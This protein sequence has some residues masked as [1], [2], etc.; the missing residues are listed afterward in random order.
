MSKGRIGFVGIGMMGLPMTGR[1]LEA[2]YEVVAYDNRKDAVDRIVAK[3]AEAASSPADV[4]SRTET[5][6][7]SLPVPDIVREVAFGKNGVASGNRRRVFVDLSTTG[8]RVAEGVASEFAQHGVVAIDAPVSG[9]V[10]GAEKGTLAVMVSGP[11]DEC[12][13]LRPVFD[14]IGKYFWIGDK[15]GMGQ[16]MKLMNN[17]LSATAMAATTEAIVL[18]VKGGLDPAVMCEVI[19]ASSGLNTATR[20]KFPKAVI[21]RTFDVGFTTG[22]MTKDVMLALAEADFHKMSMTI[23]NAV[24]ATW[25]QALAKEGAGSDLTDIVKMMEEAAGVTVGRA[26]G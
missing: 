1:L 8:P 9:G 19:N 16:M 25:L 13:K 4:A 20:D 23:G 12:E 6:F 17:L 24:K 10:S 18:G 14:I 26:K 2:G 3:G 5:V 15:P 22:L 7:V 11:K 21:P